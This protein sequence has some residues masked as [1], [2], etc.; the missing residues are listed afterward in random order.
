MR[1]NILCGQAECVDA[2]MVGAIEYLLKSYEE[3]L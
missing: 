1:V 3:E 2:L